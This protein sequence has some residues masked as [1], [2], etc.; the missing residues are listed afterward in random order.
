[1]WLFQHKVLSVTV[2]RQFVLII[3]VTGLISQSIFISVIELPLVVCFTCVVTFGST[4]FFKYRKLI[5]CELSCSR[6][7]CDLVFRYERTGSLPFLPL[8]LG[9]GYRLRHWSLVAEEKGVGGTPSFLYECIF[10][11]LSVAFW[12]STSPDVGTANE[13]YKVQSLDCGCWAL[14]IT[15]H[16]S[17]CYMLTHCWSHG[18]CYQRRRCSDCSQQPLFSYAHSWRGNTTCKMKA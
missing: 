17:C 2:L 4:I 3:L 1:M 11:L 10:W 6:S 13:L 15:Q 18:C 5:S 9:E 14:L 16:D 8:S 7:V 12:F